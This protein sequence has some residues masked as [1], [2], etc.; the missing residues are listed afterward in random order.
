MFE[1]VSLKAKILMGSSVT[2]LFLIL[3]GAVSLTSFNRL[4]ENSKWVDHTHVV[5]QNAMQIEAAAVDMETGMRGYLLAGKEEFLG[6]YTRGKKRFSTLVEA[7]KD[8][9]ADNPVQVTLLGKIEETTEE[10]QSSVTENAIELRREIGDARTMNDMAALV[11]EAQG[12][13]YFDKFRTQVATFIG[14]E[15]VLM[16]TRQAAAEKSSNIGDLK[17]TVEWVNHTNEVIQTAMRIEAAAVDMETGMRGYLLAGKEEF[18]APYKV[19]RNRFGQLVNGLKV[20][21]NDNPVQ[22]ALL[23]DMESTIEDWHT[24]VTEKTIQLRRQIGDAKTMDDMASLVGKALGKQYFDKFREQIALFRDREQAL[25]TDRQKEAQNT[26]DSTVFI[27]AAGVFIIVIISLLTVF[28]VSNSIT[29]PFHSIFKGLSSFSAKELQDLGDSFGE[30]VTKMSVSA[31]RVGSVSRN[32]ADIS[33]NLAQISN[34][35]SSSVEETSAST[36]QIAAMVDSNVKSAQESRDLSVQVGDSMVELNDAMAKIEDSNQQIV[37]LV[38]IIDEIGNKTAIIDEIVFQTKL[39]SFNASVEAERAGEHGR[40]FAVV[41]QEVGNL[42]QMSGKA[43]TDISE[44][45]KHSVRQ[46]E[47]IAA[48]NSKR[49]EE[50]IAIVR[51]TQRQSKIVASGADQIF[52]ASNEQARG[53]QEISRAIEA[54]NK[55][56]Q[57]A[58]TI[59]DQATGSSSELNRQANEL[60][61]LVQGLNSFLKG[62]ENASVTAAGNSASDGASAGSHYNDGDTLDD[63]N[64]AYGEDNGG[65]TNQLG[66][67]LDAGN[68]Q[69]WARL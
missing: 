42:A 19:G 57:H 29:L 45:V 56:T 66:R 54:I 37:E 50:G 31:G 61:R 53:I 55:A 35:Q 30:I 40:G 62:R 12:K 21:V 69:A 32:M 36:T 58:S 2:L 25:M 4:Q 23:G 14:R 60:N 9:V 13:Q 34:R 65:H 64:V 48:Q 49:V 5:I 47:T 20:T 59:A 63:H 22:V 44:I 7:L 46:A 17:S 27:L 38:K 68:K 33:Q 15:R 3:I 10:W 26:I 1:N 67:S 16:R 11:G 6:P 41:A 24:N 18:L 43:A 52:E 28:F 8:T 39:L 51:E